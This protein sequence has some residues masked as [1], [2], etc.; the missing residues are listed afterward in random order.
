MKS[1]L[2]ALLITAVALSACSNSSAA[3]TSS[4]APSIVRPEASPPPVTSA[5]FKEIVP[6]FGETGA[7][8]RA[9][10]GDPTQWELVSGGAGSNT[11]SALGG[12][13]PSIGANSWYAKP[14]SGSKAR[15]YA[16]CAKPALFKNKTIV[17]PPQLPA[18]NGVAT[19]RCPNGY[20]LL[21]GAGLTTLPSGQ[22]F[23]GEYVDMTVTNEYT[24]DGGVAAQ[25]SCG[26]ASA[27][28]FIG[29]QTAH[30][31]TSLYAA[32]PTGYSA[33]GGLSG[34]NDWPQLPY[35]EH[36]G[37]AGQP[38]NAGLGGWWVQG[39]P[40]QAALVSWVACVRT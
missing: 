39:N 14:P 8:D 10:C 36:A 15:A 27:F 31:P 29:N 17:W 24:A 11:G 38:G 13:Y 4:F 12:G 21:S 35:Q 9:D 22:K 20:V 19:A 32:C 6:G 18:A 25:I 40:K 34:I 37:S 7:I 33:V 28:K 16:I 1:P 23:T 3:S 30:Y 5:D 26:R 2:V